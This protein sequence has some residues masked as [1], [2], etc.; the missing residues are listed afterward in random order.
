[1]KNKNTTPVLWIAWFGP[2]VGHRYGVYTML[3][4]VGKRLRYQRVGDA[5]GFPRFNR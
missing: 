5:L 3:F 4:V 1:M 2:G